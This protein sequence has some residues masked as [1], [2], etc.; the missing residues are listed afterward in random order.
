MNPNQNP[1]HVVANYP[2]HYYHVNP[3]KFNW[4]WNQAQEI[5]LAT[6]TT[7]SN[8]V[9]VN[10]AFL[11][12]TIPL[13]SGMPNSNRIIVNPKFF[14]HVQN[15][16]ATAGSSKVSEAQTLKPTPSLAPTDHIK[17]LRN[18]NAMKISPQAKAN[19]PH[20]LNLKMPNHLT[21]Y[22]SST[23][24]PVGDR[25]KISKMV[26]SQGKSKYKWRKLESPIKLTAT[27]KQPYRLVRKGLTIKSQKVV[28]PSNV[29]LQNE[30]FKNLTP[31][32][33]TSTPLGAIPTFTRFKLDNRSKTKKK[34]FK[35]STSPRASITKVLQSKYQLVRNKSSKP[36][37]LTPVKFT[38]NR[39]IVNRSFSNFKSPICRPLVHHGNKLLRL[40]NVVKTN[41]TVKKIKA[42]K[43][44]TRKRYYDDDEVKAKSDD[45]VLEGDVEIA[46]K[47]TGSKNRAPL[48]V[49]PS[50]ITL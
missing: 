4:Q 9:H 29:R 23:I 3:A 49:L 8:V 14:P 32:K 36:A 30:S 46:E 37:L 12:P 20:Y 16:L 1:S 18:A 5:P 41:K 7:R 15:D 17:S 34:V 6:A 19:K 38:V 35:T 40:V 44:K 25:N 10:P 33:F 50:F 28:N 39:S 45:E 43:N 13:C 47:P 42:T 11:Q 2:P 22:F 27:I 24:K 26:H 31:P 48:G 21:S